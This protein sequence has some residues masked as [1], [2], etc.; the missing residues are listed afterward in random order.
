MTKNNNAVVMASLKH[1]TISP[2]CNTYE[3]FYRA[4]HVD[5]F[6]VQT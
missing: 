5:Q 1:V 3:L 2:P 4:I 6:T